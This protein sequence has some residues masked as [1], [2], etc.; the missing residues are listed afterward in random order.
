MMD[1]IAGDRPYRV[2]IKCPSCKA[3]EFINVGL[4]A[5]LDQTR[6]GA[7]LGLKVK[8]DT[9]DHVCGQT[10]IDDPPDGQPEGQEPLFDEPKTGVG[11]HWA[12][13]GDGE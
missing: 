10:T 12:D 5:R 4:V 11:A 13:G 6:A 9:V 7:H 1:V 8:A 2:L 3:I